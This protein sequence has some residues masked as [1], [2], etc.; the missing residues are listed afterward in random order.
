MFGC[1]AH[2]L[3]LTRRVPLCGLHANLLTRSS[4]D[5]SRLPGT[6]CALSAALKEF[7]AIGL[8]WPRPTISTESG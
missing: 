6:S 2:K 8:N 1:V 5:K 4:Q 7:I 3:S